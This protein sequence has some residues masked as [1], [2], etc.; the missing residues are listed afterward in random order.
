MVTI[1]KGDPHDTI[2]SKS[3]LNHI[4]PR[5][6]VSKAVVDLINLIYILIL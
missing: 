3:G 2:P 6:R 1:P 4:L 5:A